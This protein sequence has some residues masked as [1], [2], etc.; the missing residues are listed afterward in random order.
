MNDYVEK[1]KKELGELMPDY[2]IESQAVKKNNGIEKIGIICRN[3]DE[4]T[5]IAPVMYVT[6]AEAAI[7]TP[8]IMAEHLHRVYMENKDHSIGFDVSRFSDYEWIKENITFTIV[9]QS[10]NIEMDRPMLPIT[11]D[12]VAMFRVYVGENASIPIRNEHLNLWGNPTV[13]E[14]MEHAARNSAILDKAVF[15]TMEEMLFGVLSEIND[16]ENADLVDM[17]DATIAAGG[18]GMYVLTTEGQNDSALLY[19]DVMEGIRA[20]I[21]DLYILPSSIHETIIISKE[22]GDTMGGISALTDMVKEVNS[23]TVEPTEVLSD[24]P[25]VYDANGLH[26]VDI[27]QTRNEEI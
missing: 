5:S 10:R 3:P 22:L 16:K 4:N 9:S 25:L 11:G 8:E 1:V 7:Y 18:T 19:K 24:I 6:E 14:L 15:K 27:N 26:Q 17:I 23:T 21:G 20:K 2:E 13:E 12:L